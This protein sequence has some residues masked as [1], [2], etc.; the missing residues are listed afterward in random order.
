MPYTLHPDGRMFCD[1]IDEALAWL[2]AVKTAKKAQLKDVPKP[3]LLADRDTVD[4]EL[5]PS[6]RDILLRIFAQTENRWYCSQTSLLNE[7]RGNASRV[8]KSL[9]KLAQLGLITRV[10]V[11][12]EEKARGSIR[13]RNFWRIQRNA[14]DL[15][16]SLLYPNPQEEVQ[17]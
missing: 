1:T 3:P 2:E 9:K 5:S 12:K 13:N 6:E 15:V 11:C 7:T 16:T 17:S 4:V 14:T 8:S 10:N